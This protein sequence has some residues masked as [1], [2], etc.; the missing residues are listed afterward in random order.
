M[1]YNS[2]RIFLLTAG[3]KALLQGVGGLRSVLRSFSSQQLPWAGSSV[4]KEESKGG[5][6]RNIRLFFKYS[7]LDI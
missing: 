3:E 7:V 2:K 4:T 6:S 1:G 5:V